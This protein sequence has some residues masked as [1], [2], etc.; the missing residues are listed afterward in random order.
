MSNVLPFPEKP[1]GDGG[2]G[3]DLPSRVARIEGYMQHVATK[4]DIWKALFLGLVAV[5][6]IAISLF[7][8]MFQPFFES[9]FK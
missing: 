3:E 1:P 6:G 8:L 4:A 2:G 9:L 7:K 5:T